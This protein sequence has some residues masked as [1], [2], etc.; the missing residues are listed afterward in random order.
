MMHLQ[1]CLVF[2]VRMILLFMRG[3]NAKKK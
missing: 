1:F 2:F 3:L